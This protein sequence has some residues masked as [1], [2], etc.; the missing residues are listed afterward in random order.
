MSPLLKQMVPM[1]SLG[2][3]RSQPLEQT[4]AEQKRKTDVA[5]GW[6]FENLDNAADRLLQT[7]KHLESKMEREAKY[8]EQ[9]LSVS[10]GGWSLCRMSGERHTIGVRFGFAEGE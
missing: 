6:N 4:A 7:A 3:I 1:G 2:F 8:W 10:E 9:I 5:I